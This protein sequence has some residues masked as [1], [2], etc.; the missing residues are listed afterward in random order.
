ME[1]LKAMRARHSC[2]DFISGAKVDAA[3]IEQILYAGSIA[4]IGRP[5]DFTPHFTV[6][7]N[8]ELIQKINDVQ[9]YNVTYGATSIIVISC[10]VADPAGLD[11]ANAGCAATQ[12][13]LAAADLGVASIY[14]WGPQMAMLKDPQL[15]AAVGIPEGFTPMSSVALGK[16]DAPAQEKAPEIKTTVNYVK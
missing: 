1:T 3:D 12:M 8:Q 10:P 15:L 5:K 16:T 6:I 7:E 11:F 13:C 4:P 14:L 2:R 9:G